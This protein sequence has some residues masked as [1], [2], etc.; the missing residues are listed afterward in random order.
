[1]HHE[2]T[3]EE[4]W[5]QKIMQTKRKTKFCTSPV[6]YTRNKCP[7]KDRLSLKGL[8]LSSFVR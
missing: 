8:S 6:L 5:L 1:M 2:P 7:D 3:V 4:K